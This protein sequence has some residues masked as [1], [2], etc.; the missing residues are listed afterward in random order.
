MGL[1]TN[2]ASFSRGNRSGHYTKNDKNMKIWNWSKWKTRITLKRRGELICLGN[3]R[4]SFLQLCVIFAAN[5]VKIFK[6][7]FFRQKV[8]YFQLQTNS[9]MSRFT[10]P[11]QKFELSKLTLL[12]MFVKCECEISLLIL[13]KIVI[14][15]STQMCTYL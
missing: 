13:H 10:W 1:K 4:S 11:L 2:R 5:L 8:I 12:S 7:Y 3:S 9:V 15:I 6:A 14:I